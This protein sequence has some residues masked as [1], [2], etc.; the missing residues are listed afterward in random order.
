[1]AS[2]GDSNAWRGHTV[3]LFWKNYLNVGPLAVQVGVNCCRKSCGFACYPEAE[4]PAQLFLLSGEFAFEA[5]GYG[6]PGWVQPAL[7][8][9]SSSHCLSP[10][11]AM[12]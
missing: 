7:S 4:G 10:G 3:L 1:M 8:R 12:L 9:R 6:F 2:G 11:I 5:G